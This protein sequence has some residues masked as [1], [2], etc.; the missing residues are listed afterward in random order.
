M[1]YENL[2][3]FFCTKTNFTPIHLQMIC[4]EKKHLILLFCFAL[5]CLHFH[6]W[7]ETIDV[8]KA[9]HGSHFVHTRQQPLNFAQ[10]HYVG[11]KFKCWKPHECESNLYSIHLRELDKKCTSDI[12]RGLLLPRVDLTKKYYFRFEISRASFWS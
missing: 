9:W 3:L 6:F 1:L 7:P 8:F 10:R 2:F 4:K 12:L 5:L 11:L